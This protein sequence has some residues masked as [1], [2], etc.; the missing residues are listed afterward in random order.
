MATI[1]FDGVNK[2]IEIGYDGPITEVTALELYSRWK[3]WVALDNA[4][5]EPAFAESVGGNELGG[6][7]ALSGYYFLNNNLGWRIIHSDYDYQISISGDLY[8]TDPLEAFIVTTDTPRSVQFVFQRSAASYVTV[9]SGSGSAPTAA[10]VAA[11]V[12]DRPMSNHSTAGTFGKRIKEL[13][14]TLWGIR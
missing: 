14:P 4:Q 3:D 6:G 12:W 10:Q 8:P 7:T 13:L 1:T 5:Y 11:A 2:R 9:G